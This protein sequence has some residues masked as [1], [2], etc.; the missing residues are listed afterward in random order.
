MRVV[1]LLILG[2]DRCDLLG[3][4]DAAFFLGG[5]LVGDLV[6]VLVVGLAGGFGVF[7]LDAG[8]VTVLVF[9]FGDLDAAFFF[10]TPPI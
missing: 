1:F 5:D 4:L 8:L 9:L 3:D 10:F 2:L 6:E 7:G